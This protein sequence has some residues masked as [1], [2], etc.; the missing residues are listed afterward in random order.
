[1]LLTVVFVYP[2][3]SV[4]QR[5]LLPVPSSDSALEARADSA[6]RELILSY[7]RS[8]FGSGFIY[9]EKLKITQ[10]LETDIYLSDLFPLITS[11]FSCTFILFRLKFLLTQY[12]GTV[13]RIN[14]SRMSTWQK[15]QKH[16]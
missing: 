3:D 4:C 14:N 10:T 2:A 9:R 7:T 15:K 11:L 12:M 8:I 6:K 16:T 13:L 5:H 1:M